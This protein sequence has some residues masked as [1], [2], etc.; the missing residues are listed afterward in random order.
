MKI[1]RATQADVT[2]ANEI[3][4]SARKFM[5]ESGNPD[6]WADSYPSDKDILS[7]IEDGTSFVCE[8]EGEIIATFYFR[9]GDDPTYGKIYGGKWLSEMPYAVIHR[10]AVKHHGRGIAG[11]IYGECFKMH[12]NLRIDTHRDNLPM[13]Y[14]LSRAGFVKCGIIHLMNGDERVAYQKI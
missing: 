7:G 13:Q 3:Y 12:P 1:R 10:I 5:R 2:A 6:Q 4:I 14:S 11:F 8:D 9:I